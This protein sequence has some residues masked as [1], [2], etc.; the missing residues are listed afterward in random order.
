L[1][2]C[3]P[4][5][6][7]LKKLDE[8]WADVGANTVAAFEARL[9]DNAQRQSQW[10]ESTRAGYFEKSWRYSPFLFQLEKEVAFKILDDTAAAHSTF[11][12]H[13][14]KDMLAIGIQRA[15]NHGDT[16]FLKD[17]LHTWNRINFGANLHQTAG[18]GYNFASLVHAMADCDVELVKGYMPREMGLVPRGVHPLSR[19]GS[20]LVTLLVHE[21]VGPQAVESTLALAD[22][23]VNRKGSA[24]SDALVIRYLAALLRR[25]VVEAAQC[26]PQIAIGYR[27]MNWIVEF[28]P[29]LKFF[30]TFVHGLYNLAHHA[31]SAEQFAQIGVPEHPVFWKDFD[32]LTKQRQFTPGK[33]VEGFNLTGELSGLRRLFDDFATCRVVDA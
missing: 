23:F 15:L 8:L 12:D 9:R 10:P 31:L 20:N 13:Y 22:I 17:A 18:F 33:L 24:K 32:S 1:S 7:P 5:L 4:E 19:V 14:N 11:S 2:S 26:L 6:Q 21:K 3:Q 27:K 25:D 28:N 30:G 16:A 29:W